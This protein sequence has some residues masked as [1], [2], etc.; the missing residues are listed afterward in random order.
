MYTKIKGISY[1]TIQSNTRL[2]DFEGVKDIVVSNSVKNV[3]GKLKESNIEPDTHL[4]YF[5]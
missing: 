1:K 2:S 4:N 5:F 3:P